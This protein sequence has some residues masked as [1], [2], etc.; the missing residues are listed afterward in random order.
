VLKQEINAPATQPS[1]RTTFRTVKRPAPL[2]RP[3]TSQPIGRLDMPKQKI[4]LAG[5]GAGGAGVTAAAAPVPAAAAPSPSAP[6]AVPAPGNARIAAMINPNAADNARAGANATAQ[7][8][9][10]Y[11]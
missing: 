8:E 6:A 11:R 5:D 9:D 10:R 4:F 3:A 2:T 7:A 1:K